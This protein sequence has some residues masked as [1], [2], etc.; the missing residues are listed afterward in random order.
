MHVSLYHKVSVH[1][2][3]MSDLVADIRAV[4]YLSLID[5]TAN[6]NKLEF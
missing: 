3:L 2:G 1:I 6:S 4:Y 5:N